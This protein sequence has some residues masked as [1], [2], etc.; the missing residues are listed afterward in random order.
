MYLRRAYR[1]HPFMLAW[2]FES[3]TWI[4][5]DKNGFRKTGMFSECHGRT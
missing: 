1:A 3:K 4:I 5:L 2:H